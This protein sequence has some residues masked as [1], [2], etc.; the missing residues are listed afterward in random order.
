[1]FQEHT[2]TKHR[3]LPWH[4]CPLP[5]AEAEHLEVLQIGVNACWEAPLSQS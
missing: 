1:M 3:L 4:M 5:A 2:P